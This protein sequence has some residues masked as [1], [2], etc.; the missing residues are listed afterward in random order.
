M[1][2]SSHWVINWLT[3]SPLLLNYQES[4]VSKKNIRNIPTLNCHRFPSYKLDTLLSTHTHRFN[5][6]IKDQLLPTKI[7]FEMYE[8]RYEQTV[9]NK[10]FFFSKIESRNP[11]T[12]LDANLL[13]MQR[14]VCVHTDWNPE[15]MERGKKILPFGRN[16]HSFMNGEG[17]GIWYEELDTAICQKLNPASLP[18][19]VG[20]VGRSSSRVIFRFTQLRGG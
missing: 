8:I 12:R 5:Y 19:T 4:I 20:P 10:I 16:R 9:S 3:D 6:L 18:D 2:V 13:H 1:V 11:L 7:S 17:E 15:R 14:H